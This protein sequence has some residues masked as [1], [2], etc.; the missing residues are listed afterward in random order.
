MADNYPRPYDVA[1]ILDHPALSG[2]DE[3][4]QEVHEVDS[5]SHFY[6]TR[7]IGHERDIT[8]QP[9]SIDSDEL[10][11][12]NQRQ[13]EARCQ[14]SD[15]VQAQLRREARQRRLYENGFDPD[16]TGE[17]AWDDLEGIVHLHRQSRGRSAYENT[18]LDDTAPELAS[19][20]PPQCRSQG[21]EQLD[22]TELVADFIEDRLELLQEE[23]EQREVEKKAEADLDRIVDILAA[24]RLEIPAW[25]MRIQT[26][27][28]DFCAKDE[29]SFRAFESHLINAHKCSKSQGRIW[30]IG[31]MFRKDL[32]REL[33][34]AVADLA[35]CELTISTYTLTFKRIQVNKLDTHG[36]AILC[37]S[38]H[39]FCN[40]E[41]WQSAVK[42]RFLQQNIY[43]G[44]DY[45]H[46]LP[47]GF[48]DYQAPP[49]ADSVQKLAEHMMASLETRKLCC[50]HGS[51]PAKRSALR[52]SFSKFTIKAQK[53][54]DD[55]LHKLLGGYFV[56]RP[57]E[58]SQALADNQALVD[59]Q[60][61]IRT[62]RVGFGLTPSDDP[63]DLE[64]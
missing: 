61:A 33:W 64:I 55:E 4:L 60:K 27:A 1:S 38:Y 34:R 12:M 36:V 35:A 22:Y 29:K 53:I 46:D 7:F 32:P 9:G 41:T 11:A 59:I 23:S 26:L 48:S 37:C 5:I 62:A 14:R 15:M 20:G 24:K 19:T 8:L 56:P 51:T 13:H 10:E 44:D 3:Y 42:N 54:V 28:D 17:S 2:L 40:D 52:A 49:E 16:A 25:K 18:S 31:M 6:E 57:G 30:S 43:F 50:E 63:Y 47:N 21:A 45:Q 58:L 39:T